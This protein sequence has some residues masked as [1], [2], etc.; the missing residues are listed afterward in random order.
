MKSRHDVA[1]RVLS[2][3]ELADYLHVS[4]ATIYRL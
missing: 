4:P 3:G 2:V 1:M